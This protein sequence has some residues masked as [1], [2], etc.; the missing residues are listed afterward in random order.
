MDHVA[1]F[2]ELRAGVVRTILAR[3]ITLGVF[4]AIALA[5]ML[6]ARMSLLNPL[7]F[8]PF[9]WFLLTFPFGYLI[10]RQATA[11]RLNLVHM[12]FFLVEITLITVL[13]H[14][15][16][17]VEWIGITFYLFTVIYANFFLPRP[18][19][20][21]VTGLAVAFYAVLVIAEYLG[22]IPHKTLFAG[23]AEPYRNL[24]YV[25]TTIVCGGATVYAIV[26][27]T[28]RWF[29]AVYMQK[30]RVLA[31]RE[32]QLARMSKRLVHAQDDE[33][34]RIATELH[35]ELIQSLAAIKLHLTPVSDR[36]GEEAF[37]EITGIVDQAI[38]QTRT[39]A[40]SLRPPL[41]DDLGLVPS[42]KR[43]AATIEE[44]GGPKVRLSCRVD[45]PLDVS[46][47]S[48]LFFV[49]QQALMNV[50]RHARAA[51]VL[52]DLQTKPGSVRLVIEDD[53]IGFRPRD[54]EGLGLRGI[55]E[56]VEI[57]GGSVVV[58]SSPWNGTVIRVEVPSHAD[59]PVGR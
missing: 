28:V 59:S 3:R 47:E 30:N 10:Q 5:A 56:R 4:S 26:A 46:L 41:L 7:F 8:A 23:E 12:C 49:A 40:Y 18:H 36:M 21:V 25:I 43:L 50:V 11:R 52:I 15:M 27:F 38:S 57:S 44:E 24:F 53:G 22:W 58:E 35:D 33:R 9:V 6:L 45:R 48:L 37:D 19:G 20:A 13:I 17:G 55:R 1:G 31:A 32:T 42:L 34:R 51:Q 14:F 39:L 16:G 2:D 54:G 29:T